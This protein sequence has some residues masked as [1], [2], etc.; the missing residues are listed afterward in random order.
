MTAQNSKMLQPVG[1]DKVKIA[2]KFWKN[3]IDVNRK[4]TLKT[5]YDICKKTGRIDAMKLEPEKT[6]AHPFWDSDV[7][8]WVE[9]TAYALAARRDRGMEAKVDR[10]A[11]LMEKAQASDGYLNSYYQALKPRERW[12]NLKDMHEL[13]CAGHLMEAAVAYYEATGKRKM[14]DVMCRY[15]DHIDR[16]F[17]P[18]KGK[19]KGYPGHEEIELALVKLY[20]ATGEKRYLRLAEFFVNERGKKPYYFNAELETRGEK[21]DPADMPFDTIQAHLPVREQK[22]AEGHSVRAMYLYSGMADVAAETGDAS[23][24]QACRRLWRNVTQKRMYVTGGVGSTRHGERFTFDYDLPNESA[25]AETCAAI[26]LVFFAHRMLHMDRDG[27]YADVME[28]ALYNNVLS[29]VSV[30]GK[31]FFYDNLLAAH[32][33]MCEYTRQKPSWRQ[34]W[35]RTCCCPT[36]IVRILGSFGKYIYSSSF[37]EVR[38]NL[39]VQ[40]SADVEVGDVPVRITQKTDYPWDGKICFSVDPNAPVSMNLALRIPGWCRKPGVKV[41]GRNVSLSGITRKGYA[42]IRRTWNKGDRVKLDLPMPVEQMEAHPNVRHDCGQVALQ[43]GP[44]VYCLEEKDNGPALADISISERTRFSVSFNKRLLGGVP[45]ITCKG[46]RRSAKGWAGVL[47]RPCR[48]AEKQVTVR[49]VPYC[50]WNNRGKGEMRVW[51]N[52]S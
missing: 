11:K 1:L 10:Y 9:G 13:Y 20:R 23:L 44:V 3:R 15:A 7:A 33:K 29:G 47:Y 49:A 34:E 4:V 50:L 37:G 17:G 26:G 32:P 2:D 31:M 22:T 51:I 8:K 41:N 21:P 46:R 24:K 43:R 30:D 42:M 12:S 48:S 14:L 40:G 28:R 25:Y 27:R 16:T 45:V 18:E 39:F 38:V 6:G 36:N 35:F 52:R 19:L 5:A